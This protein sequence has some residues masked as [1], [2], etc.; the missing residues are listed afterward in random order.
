MMEV[1]SWGRPPL[2]EPRVHSSDL[3]SPRVPLQEK[4][5]RALGELALTMEGT[6]S[7]HGMGWT[8]SVQMCATQIHL[9]EKDALKPQ[10][11]VS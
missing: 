5:T 2:R 6:A 4:S 10:T 3:P 9:T 11:M 8:R 1:Q 7:T